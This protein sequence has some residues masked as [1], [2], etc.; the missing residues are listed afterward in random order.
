MGCLGV[1]HMTSKSLELPMQTVS[2]TLKHGGGRNYIWG[3]MCIY[4]LELAC[5]EEG[6]RYHE[7]VE[8]NVGKRIQKFH[9]DTSRVIFQQDN[10]PIHTTKLLQE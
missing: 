4:G 8:R 6:H 2:Q 1:G 5:K 7:F 10:A 9:V 3:R